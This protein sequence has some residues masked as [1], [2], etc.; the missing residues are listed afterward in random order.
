MATSR[1]H[2]KKNTS[3][4]KIMIVGGAG[5]I[6]SKITLKLI[7]LGHNVF[8]YD[9]YFNFIET[10]RAKYI[11][12]LKKRLG[13]IGDSAVFINND[14]RNNKLLM[15]ALLEYQP[16]TIVHL[17]QIPLA[18]VSNKFSSEALDINFN[19]LVNIIKSIGT[20][21]FVKRLVYASSS[22][23]YGNFK[24]SPADENHPT[25]PIDVYGGTKLAGENIIK[26]FGTRF[27]IDYTIIRPSAVYGP[28]DCNKRV[29]Q[30]FIE[31]A[32]ND[33]EIILEGGGENFLDFSYIDDVAEGFVLAILSNKA[34]NEIFN[35]TRGEARSLKNLAEILKTYYPKLKSR[36]IPADNTRPKRG[37]LNINKAKTILGYDPKYSLE[38]GIK[39]YINYINQND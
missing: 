13:T 6:G 24:Y 19:G 18:N 26:G 2:I 23:V 12:S 39:E 21:N 32:I 25:N 5:F 17:A 30:I 31:N 15:S 33:K 14:V 20:V 36:V 38:E 29:C 37:A 35:I 28:T 11:K 3:A 7:D 22:F 8:V 9:R 27:G 34:K 4:R 16:D 10:G 1:T